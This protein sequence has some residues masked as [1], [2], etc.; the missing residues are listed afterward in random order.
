MI[1]KNC[2]PCEPVNI[3]K[4]LL[5]N[6]IYDNNWSLP[7]KNSQIKSQSFHGNAEQVIPVYGETPSVISS[8]VLISYPITPIVVP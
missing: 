8:V 2:Y 5:I 7:T 3:Q 4:R 6:M 1:I